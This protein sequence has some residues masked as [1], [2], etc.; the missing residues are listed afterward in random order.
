MGLF[1]IQ[2]VVFTVNANDNVYTECPVL[3]EQYADFAAE[4]KNDVLVPEHECTECPEKA[5]DCLGHGH[6]HGQC[7]ECPDH[8]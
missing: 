4:G 7:A 2:A 1:V 8:K 3:L 6:T 5:A